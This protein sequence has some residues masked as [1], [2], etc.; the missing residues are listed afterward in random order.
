MSLL[1]L[2][3]ASALAAPVARADEAA[4]ARAKDLFRRG[5]ILFNASDLERALELFLAS[6][7][8]FPSVQNTSNA[9]ICLDR[10]G[11]HDEALELY[12]QLLTE[13]PSG[14]PE[15]ESRA[16]ASAMAALRQRVG[17][18]WLSADVAGA[19]VV[20]DGRARGTLPLVVP[21][22][23]LPGSRLVRV[24]KD[25]YITHE[26]RVD[27]AAA[28]EARLEVRLRPL[29]DAGLLR[30]EDPAPGAELFVD[31]ARVG[32]TPWEGT[33]GP[34]RHVVWTTN[35]DA[36]TV[37]KEVVV[38]QGQKAVV[39]VDAKPL[40]HPLSIEAEP[41]TAAIAIDGVEVA[42]GRYRGRLPLGDHR[43]T[44]M[45]DGYRTLALAVRSTVEATPIAPARLEVDPTHPRWPRAAPGAVVLEL[46]NGY[47][48]APRLGS[49]AERNCERCP[50]AVFAHGFVSGV[51]VGYRFPAGV[52][53]ALMGGYLRLETTFAR[54][55][56]AA[57]PPSELPTLAYDLTDRMRIEAPLGAFGVGYRHRL[58]ERFSLGGN[59]MVGAAMSVAADALDVTLSAG[60]ERL[61]GVVL[62][63]E[64]EARAGVVL[65]EAD[66]VGTYR[67]GAWDLGL[68]VAV[69]G[70]FLD[71]PLLERRTIAVPYVPGCRAD[72]LACVASGAPLPDERA[73]RNLLVVSPQLVVGRSF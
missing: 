27:V 55:L 53:L 15:E 60:T 47:A 25:G 30:I 69:L 62:R 32:V 19:S 42:R 13:F 71:G 37:P 33:L 66:V 26:A 57:P 68:A 44:I 16:V 50:G 54:T 48:L 34:G 10:L 21:I 72:Q 35:G 36:G 59:A 8:A 43:I 29:A 61:S 73:H 11:R 49:E 7:A 3:L 28:G 4:V 64:P 70:L 9:A 38:V 2:L 63:A 46:V 58:G 1:V 24:I 40:G 18:V 65:A 23:V 56:A 17:S 5:V 6:R 14:I 12:E 39:T 22:R 51:R 20:I 31:G 41:A 45:E 52:S 67:V